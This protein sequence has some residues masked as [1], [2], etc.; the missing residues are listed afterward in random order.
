MDQQ[1]IKIDVLLSLQ[2]YLR[3]NYWVLF[4]R[5]K[6]AK[7]MIFMLLFVGVAYPLYLFFNADPLNP[8]ESYW[9]LLAPWIVLLLIFGGTYLETKRQL[10]SS[11]FLH[12]TQRYTFTEEGVET[13]SLSSSGRQSW[14]LIREA[15]ETEN[16]FLLFISLTQMFI[17]PKRCF[18]SSEHIKQF[19]D[20]LKNRLGSKAKIK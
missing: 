5:Y 10:A 14:G 17:I 16:N 3:A 9:G 7:A 18:Q 11:K 8:N 15:F 6:P 20:L 12:E 19:K 4:R 13:A 2:D 1:S